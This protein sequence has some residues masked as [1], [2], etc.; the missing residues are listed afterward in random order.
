MKVVKKI[1][2]L[3]CALILA[4]CG[5]G[6]D[7]GGGSLSSLGTA[8]TK[9]ATAT[10]TA[11]ATQTAATAETSGKEVAGTVKK[12]DGTWNKIADEGQTISLASATVVQY[13]A[14]DSWVQKTVTGSLSCTNA[15]F[16][17]DPSPN[18]AKACYSQAS[19]GGSTSTATLLASENQNFTVASATVV[20]YGAGSAWV[21]KTVTGTAAC[22]NGYFGQDPA[23]NVAKA[24]YSIGSSST[25]SGTGT[26]TTTRL[27]GEDQTFTVAAATVV[28]YG[29]GSAWVQKTVTGTATC[30]NG[31]FGQDPAP[32]VAKACYSLG[33]GTATGG[34]TVK[35]TT[36]TTRLAGENENFT[37]ASATL[38]QY[39]AG[40]AWV[41][42]TVTGAATCSN[43]YFGQD[44]APNVAKACYSVGSGTTTGGST[45]ESTGGGSTTV[46]PVVSTGEPALDNNILNASGVVDAAAYRNTASMMGKDGGIA[47]RY[48]PSP[49]SYGTT[50]NSGYPTYAKRNDNAF[51][52]DQQGGQRPCN[53]GNCGT[54]QL[55]N[56]SN[57][58]GGYSSNFGHVGFIPD[59]ASQNVGFSGLAISSQSN[60]V[61]SQ[62]P[63]LSWTLYGWGLDEINAYDYRA[64]GKDASNPVA[65]GR[66]Y[67]RP[68]WC[69]SSIM[70][71]QNGL[72]GVAGNPT[73]KN[74]ATAQLAAN[75]V[76]T[77]IAV[78]NSG[79]FAFI[80]VW[81]TAN[82][83]GEIAVVALAGLCD[84]C[85]PGSPSK[86]SS[87]WGEWNAV[88][89]GL[90]N[91]GNIA[92]MKVLGYVPLPAD[93]KA[94]TEISVTTGVDRNAYLQA[95][96][97]GYE[98][99]ASLTLNSS[100][101]RNSFRAGQR[102]YNTYAKTGVAVV[103][104]KSEQKVAFVDLKPLF[105]Y[106]QSMYF[107]S[108]ADYNVTANLG[109]GDSQWPR[110]FSAASQQTPTVIKTMS[111][112][113]RPTAVKAY[114]WGANRR[115]WVATQ[116]GKL[117][118]FN[119]GDFPTAGTGS[120]GSIT[121]GA[122]VD[123]G[124]NPTG[125]A[126]PKEKAGGSVYGSNWMNDVIVTS[127]GDRQINW[128]RFAGD[129]NS[130]SV[131]RTLRDSRLVD[132]IS[133][134]DTDNHSTESYVLSV[135]DY[136]GRALRNYRYGPV[137]MHNYGGQNYGM[138]EAF[139]YGGAYD[140]PGKAFHVT[141][142][143]IP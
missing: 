110:T 125:I 105:Q 62:K 23:P 137:I 53:P 93:M 71:W 50:G 88:Y 109:D 140:L 89:P 76:P 87:W 103:V 141:G 102:N 132:P 130:G 115:A 112:S 64:A 118:I 127:R 16:G 73:A 18:V 10:D 92:Y 8:A 101:N 42:K 114:L 116:D 55:G 97:P 86:G 69:L 43:S 90:P 84:G 5:G 123:V 134:E 143:N 57:D 67:G 124:R 30:S 59:N 136:G 26:A 11:S 83:R 41:Q 91:V 15:F 133:V 142:A 129:M 35:D 52:S 95:G 34:D 122:S 29:A 6:S 49:A 38:V 61:F 32:N 107:G 22:S 25:G 77:A 68:G 48:G 82:L 94:P 85:T 100:A 66:C 131:V 44:P 36:A 75:K 13:G 111:V 17:Q 20:A 80:T 24:C 54:W 21:Q 113:S 99:P 46:P 74:K 51:V 72:I 106:Y 14:N 135:A 3:L 78:S 39:G 139:E 58:V 4:G 1:S 65:V 104:S 9:E 40:S 63:E 98:S 45:G 47:Y 27:A 79:E 19:T 70:V 128:V 96:V 31:Y 7:S 2:Y 108:D 117:R 28:Q 120:A 126:H 33:A 56:W 37:V 121:E 81:D 138:S 60:S 119:L 12:L